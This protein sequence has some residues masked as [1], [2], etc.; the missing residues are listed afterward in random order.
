MNDRTDPGETRPADHPS[1]PER[2]LPVVDYEGSYAVSD[3][4]RVKG[5][6]RTTE[7]GKRL[8]GRMLKPWREPDGRLAV[9]LR[10]GGIKKNH[11]VHQL[12]AAA[13]IGPQP[14]GLETRHLDDDLDNNRLTNLAYGT[15]KENKAD[16]LRNHGHYKDAIT[17]CPQGHEYTPENTY[18]G[19]KGRDC[20]RCHNDRSRQRDKDLAAGAGTPCTRDGCEDGQVG[21]GLCRKHYTKQWRADNPEA[22]KAI[23]RRSNAKRVPSGPPCSEPGCNAPSSTKGLC[24]P[25]YHKK[26]REQKKAGEAA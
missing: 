25:H 9:S 13:F 24:R 16:M 11:R 22:V 18:I 5:L 2:W 15:S 19:P 4:G 1:T 14:E 3:Q 21:N 6:P 8:S 12:V 26:W 10:K 23:Q 17:A 7:D 20:R